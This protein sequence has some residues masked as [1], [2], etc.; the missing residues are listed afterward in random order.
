MG[1]CWGGRQGLTNWAEGVVFDKCTGL[2][3]EGPPEQLWEDSRTQGKGLTHHLLK[4][5]VKHI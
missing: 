1:C 4:L 3:G 5:I 2:M